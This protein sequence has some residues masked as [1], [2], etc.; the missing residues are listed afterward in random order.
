MQAYDAAN[1]ALENARKR[2]ADIEQEFAALA[3]DLG[4]GGPGGPDFG[5]ATVAGQT[6]NS[7]VMCHL[8]V[9]LILHCKYP[10]V[11]CFRCCTILENFCMIYKMEFTI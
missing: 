9:V 8:I 3:N 10:N 2:R 5:A 11:I 6:G 1:T 4:S 7:I